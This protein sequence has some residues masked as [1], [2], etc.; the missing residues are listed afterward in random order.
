MSEVPCQRKNSHVTVTADWTQKAGLPGL[1]FFSFLVG[2]DS[3]TSLKKM[4]EVEHSTNTSD[5]DS[6]GTALVTTGENKSQ[7]RRKV[8]KKRQKHKPG[9]AIHQNI[10][11]SH[12]FSG[13]SIDC[14]S[15]NI[16]DGRK[17]KTQTNNAWKQ[18]YFWWSMAWIQV[19]NWADINSN[20]VKN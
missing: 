11:R 16:K 12:R 19:G 2:E 13:R 17:L 1:D 3:M 20:N 9:V 15:R 5:P 6:P 8:H 7:I 14:V 4:S 18:T 10:G